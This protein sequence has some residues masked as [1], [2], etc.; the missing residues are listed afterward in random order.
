MSQKIYC[1]KLTILILLY[2]THYLDRNFLIYY[3][4]LLD[5]R[6]VDSITRCINKIKEIFT[7]ITETEY[8]TTGSNT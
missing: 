8:F 6:A 4:G 5:G 2:T 3:H 1:K 7:I